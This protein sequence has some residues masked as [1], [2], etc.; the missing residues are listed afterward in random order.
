MR[1]YVKVKQTTADEVRRLATD[2]YVLPARSAGKRT[3]QINVGEVHEAVGYKSRV[4]LV[5][6]AL[7][8]MKFRNE[9]KMQLFRTDR[10]GEG[11]TTT[12]IFRLK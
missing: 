4:S 10:P 9:N 2:Q 6:A 5:A 7:G 11:T 1:E 12:Y 8:A 3:V